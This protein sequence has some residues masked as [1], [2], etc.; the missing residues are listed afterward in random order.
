MNRIPACR[1]ALVRVAQALSLLLLSSFAAAQF[2]SF[3]RVTSPNGRAVLEIRMGTMPAN[4]HLVFTAVITAGPTSGSTSLMLQ[5]ALVQDIFNANAPAAGWTVVRS[6]LNAFSLGGGCGRSN[7]IDFPYINGTR[8]EILR[9]TGTTQ[10]VITLGITNSDQYDSI[11]CRVGPTGQVLYLLTNRTRQTLE[12]RKEQGGLLQLVRDNF[13]TVRTP[14]VGGLR[15]SLFYRAVHA[16]APAQEQSAPDDEAIEFKIG[17]FFD[18]LGGP[19]PQ[20]APRVEEADD[21]E[22][23]PSERACTL[24]NRA[25]TTTFGNVNESACAGNVCIGD[26]SGSGVFSVRVF[27]F[28][29]NLCVPGPVQTFSSR[30]GGSLFNF[31]GVAAVEGGGGVGS[32]DPVASVTVVDTNTVAVFEGNNRVD[33]TNPF[34][35]RGGPK[36]ACPMIGRGTGGAVLLAGPGTLSSQLQQNVLTLPPQG[37]LFANGGEDVLEFAPAMCGENTVF[38]LGLV[39]E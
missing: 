33:L 23:H 6:S 1:R 3:T 37:L 31:A 21:A 38:G 9:I 34:A 19:P 30:S 22:P 32:G 20:L 16:V 13:G 18:L 35:G 25:D 24:G 39:S 8:P 2:P 5:Q 26:F 12:L 17:W 28:A 10:Q 4:R 14:F 36:A 27:G 15:P 29:G 11:D 7:L